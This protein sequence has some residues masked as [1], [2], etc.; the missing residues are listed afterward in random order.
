M[1]KTIKV[2]TIAII[3]QERQYAIDVPDTYP[4]EINPE[5]VKKLTDKEYDHL[6]NV[7]IPNGEMDIIENN[8]EDERFDFE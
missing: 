6:W 1:T 7:L 5:T 3:T 8:I 2:N 4:D